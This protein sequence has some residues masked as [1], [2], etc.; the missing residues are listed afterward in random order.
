[1]RHDWVD[2]IVDAAS[3]RPAWT[4]GLALVLCAAL[5]GVA[6]RLQLRSDLLELLPRD[7]PGLQALE[8]QLGR[9]GG[10]STLLVMVS[11]PDRARNERFVDDLARVLDEA[12]DRREPWARLVAYVES[13]ARPVRVFYE[14]NR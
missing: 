5:L 2:R 8:H 3:E 14:Q 12:R 1:M 4:V 11:S 13:D 10:R 6:S 9:V 7:S